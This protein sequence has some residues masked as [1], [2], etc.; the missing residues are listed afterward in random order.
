MARRS[1]SILGGGFDSALV[2]R[3]LEDALASPGDPP[4]YG[5]TGVQGCG[6]STLAAQLAA[7]G[8][9]RGLQVL[10]L[11]IDDF[12]LGRR[13][14]QALGRRVHPLLAT[15]GP[16]GTHDI[17]L[18][19]ST[20]DRLRALRPGDLVPL[21]RFDKLGDRRLRP[22]HWPQ[23]RQRPDL[24]VFEGWFLKTPPESADALRRPINQLERDEDR[25]GR[26]RRYCNEAL[27]AYQPL[28]ARIDRL[29]WLR[30][31]GFQVVPDWRWQQEAALQEA[32]GRAG[33]SRAKL[34]RFVLLF[35]RVS[36]QAE[37]SLP[38][39]ADLTVALD[40]ERRPGAVAA[41]V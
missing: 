39:I 18:A 11:S 24:I 8:K 12:Y 28:W 32:G 4:V 9:A 31:P 34:E 21:P 26:W 10:A 16:P 1:H 14:R 3:L 22:S 41:G 20:L 25:D 2:Q 13:E 30:A 33:M 7:A 37:H 38:W 15:R 19:C 27:A 35:E 17:A 29:L 40:A 23:A 5:I 6:K 36:H